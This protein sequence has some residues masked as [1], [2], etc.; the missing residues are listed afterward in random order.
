LQN[1]V[2]DCAVT[3]AGSGYSAGWWEV[4]THLLPIPLGGWDS[5]VTAMNLDRWNSLSA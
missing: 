5:V 1:G 2:V 4:S 3:G